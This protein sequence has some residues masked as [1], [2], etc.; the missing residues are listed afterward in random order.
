MGPHQYQLRGLAQRF[1][2]NRGKCGVDR[3]EGPA[4]QQLGPV[5]TSDT[6]EAMAA[7]VRLAEAS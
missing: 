5:V 7:L 2:G 4:A 3:I 6:P 1:G